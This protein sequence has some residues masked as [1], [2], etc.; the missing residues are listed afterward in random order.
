[1]FMDF[2]YN[3]WQ[4]KKKKDLSDVYLPYIC[5]CTEEGNYWGSPVFQ[6]KGS[7]SNYDVAN[8]NNNN[9][10]KNHCDLKC[11]CFKME[12]QNWSFLGL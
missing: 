7:I 2:T 8:F 3:N 5:T 12:R 4:K 6:L 9:N 11:V 10:K 1:M